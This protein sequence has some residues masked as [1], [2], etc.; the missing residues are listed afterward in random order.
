MRRSNRK[1][2]KAESGT[3]IIEFAL[4]LGFLLL[5]MVGI[6]EIGRA[7]WYYDAL[8]KA[9]RDGA[10]CVSANGIV[11]SQ[12][13]CQKLAADSANSA[14]I[15]PMLKPEDVVFSDSGG[16]V[17][18]YVTMTVRNYPMIWIWS[19]GATLPAPGDSVAIGVQAT[20]PYMQAAR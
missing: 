9:V 13:T 16:V 19:I 17:P 10:R 7:F 4:V 3:A 6:T 8:Q 20:M 15:S 12:S 2:G 5:L 14:G 1:S 18:E 11:S